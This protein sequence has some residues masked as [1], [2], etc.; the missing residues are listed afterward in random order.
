MDEDEEHMDHGG[1]KKVKETGTYSS[2]QGYQL[3]YVDIYS[4]GIRI[5]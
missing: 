5:E 3:Y 2:I 4:T 1:K